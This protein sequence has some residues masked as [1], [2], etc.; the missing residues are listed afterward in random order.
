M[1][2]TQW[3]KWPS[4]PVA[5]KCLC[6]WVLTCWMPCVTT[7]HAALLEHHQELR[8]VHLSGSP[9]DI[10]Y[11]HGSLLREEVRGCVA[12]ILGYIRGY[13]K[14]PWLGSWL[15]TAWLGKAWQDAYSFVADDYLEELRGLSDSSGVPLRELSLFHAIPDRTYACANFAA[16]KDLT[17]DG[18]LI[19]LR[20]LDWNFKVGIQEFA[21]VFV[22]RPEGK[23][24]FVNIGWAG[25]IGVLSGVNEDQISI[26]Q[27]GAETTDVTT[28]GEPMAFLMRRVL[29]EA[30]DLDE[31]SQII[32]NA[33]RMA[34]INYVIADAHA[35]TGLAIETT[36]HHERVFHANDSLEHSVSYARPMEDAVF[37]ADTAMDPVIRDLQLA[38]KGN[39]KRPGLESP[40]GSS[41]YDRRYL[42]QAQG[43]KERSG[44]LDAQGSQEI[45][46]SIAP[47]SNVQSVVIAWPDLWVA[48]AHGEIRAAYRPYTHLSLIELFNGLSK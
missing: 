45:A 47:G 13:L 38:S 37:R 20:N 35:R 5:R 33:R 29:E 28:H 42:G 18:R 8:V 6:A 48:N 46:R 25:F 31:A 32:L 11:Q 17:A 9:Y 27:I 10:G 12:Q 14:I 22:V 19:H 41:A 43:L 23:R 44:H 15:A 16:W 26:G 40:Q 36:A 30:S 1:R 3:A 2:V 34:G 24:A 4:G 7:A 39:P 21:T